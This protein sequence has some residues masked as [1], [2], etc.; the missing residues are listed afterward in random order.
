MEDSYFWRL[1]ANLRS[2]WSSLLV[3]ERMSFYR[4]QGLIRRKGREKIQGQKNA[5]LL[6][7]NMRDS[8]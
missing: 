7:E 2:E 1:W 4:L 3:I 5:L 6:K 8:D